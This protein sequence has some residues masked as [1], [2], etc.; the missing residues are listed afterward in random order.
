[1]GQSPF[2]ACPWF[3]RYNLTQRFDQRRR[4]FWVQG[5]VRLRRFNADHPKLAPA[6]NKVPLVRWER[7]LRYVSSMH[8]LNRPRFNC[9]LLGDPQAVSGALFHFKY[10]HLLGPKAREELGRREHYAQSR[11]YLAYLA[12]GDPV[13]HDP[14]VS[15]RWQD[16]RQLADLGFMQA[17][18]WY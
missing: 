1:E 8:H 15:V 13:L 7:G 14:D 10:V 18:G 3:D 12:A 17:G 11:E 5:G 6:L 4:N 9:T 16:W 2:E